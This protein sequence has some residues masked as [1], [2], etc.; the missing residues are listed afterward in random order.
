MVEI[1]SMDDVNAMSY[2]ETISKMIFETVTLAQNLRLKVLYNEATKSLILQSEHGVNSGLFEVDY[3]RLE[4]VCKMLNFISNEKNLSDYVVNVSNDGFQTTEMET[5]EVQDIK[6]DTD[7]WLENLQKRAK[8]IGNLL[9]L[10]SSEGNVRYTRTQ[11]VKRSP[12]LRQNAFV[13]KQHH[14]MADWYFKLE[15]ESMLL[16][17][18]IE[19]DEKIYAAWIEKGKP[20]T[21][22][23]RIY[24]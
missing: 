9:C 10:W 4:C 11:S 13:P 18:F 6:C 21:D 12:F 7:V 17:Q 16:Q 2:G 22:V 20:R 15:T 23:E 8:A 5:C 3:I 24:L 19:H 14:E 1:I